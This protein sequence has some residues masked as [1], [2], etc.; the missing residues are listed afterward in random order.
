MKL[1]LGPVR[2]TYVSPTFGGDDK[3]PLDPQLERRLKRPMVIG[4][5]V[6][7]AFVVGLGAWA[8][9]TPP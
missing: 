6:I 5:G 1:D 8:A 9:V 3:G 7:G 2:S 4:A